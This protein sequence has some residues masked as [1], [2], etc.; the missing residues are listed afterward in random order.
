MIMEW[1]VAPSFQNG[2]ITQVDKEAHKALVVET[3]P[4]CGGSGMYII[5]GIFT[6]T[7]FACN[8]FGKL[9]K[10]V[11]AYT[12]E[13]YDKYIAAREKARE[14]KRQKELARLAELEK[15]SD[16][17]KKARLTEFGFDAENPMVYLVVGKNSYEIKD[18]LK[19]R[20]GRYNAAF[21]WYFNAPT[22]VPEGFKL[23]SV[24]WDD[25]YDWFPKSCRME[26]KENAKEVADAAKMQLV[27]P[28]TSEF[29]GSIKERLYELKARCT[30]RREF[31]G[32][33]G[34]TNIYTFSVD[35][36]TLVWMTSANKP[37]EPDNNYLLTGTVKNH[38][39]Y[40]GEKQTYLSRCIVTV[41]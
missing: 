35:G 15:N 7:C 18:E 5:P 10:W 17:N 4:R 12:E 20:G 39:V 13:E 8:G 37:I 32:A 14:A 26:L 3:C 24:K 31:D 27:E 9:S 2:T 33:Y 28:S 22:E 40:D 6:G 25:V 1:K 19:R 36:N 38:K 16:E 23:A 34:H 30:G 11:K 41:A 29:M 21:G